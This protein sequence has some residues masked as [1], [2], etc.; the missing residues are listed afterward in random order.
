MI[1]PTLFLRIAGPQAPVTLPSGFRPPGAP[2]G[3]QFMAAPQLPMGVP[4]M[5]FPQMKKPVGWVPPTSGAE[6]GRTAGDADLG[7]YG[8]LLVDPSAGDPNAVPTVYPAGASMGG[9]SF[10]NWLRGLF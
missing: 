4:G 7:G 5:G 3:G 9:G 6:P 10:M 8:G 1:D 2:P